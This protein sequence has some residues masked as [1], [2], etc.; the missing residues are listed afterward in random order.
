[1]LA[2]EFEPAE[3]YGLWVQEMTPLFLGGNRTLTA[4]MS[5]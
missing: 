1:M 4:E 3:G 5:E 2:G